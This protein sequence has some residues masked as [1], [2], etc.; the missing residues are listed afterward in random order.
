MKAEAP[1][2]AEALKGMCSRREL[3]IAGLGDGVAEQEGRD[4]GGR[5]VDG[6]LWL[7]TARHLAGPR[8]DRLALARDAVRAGDPGPLL[9]LAADDDAAAALEAHRRLMGDAA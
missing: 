2:A 8:D 7:A 9:A 6:E 5:P 3:V 4:R 1:L